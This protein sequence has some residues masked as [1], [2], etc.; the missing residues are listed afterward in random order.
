MSDGRFRSLIVVLWVI[1]AIS[2]AAGLDVRAT[3]GARVS[4][5][6]PQYLL[7]AISLADDGNLNIDDEIDGEAYLPFSEIGLNRQT[8]N[9][10]PDKQV[11]P[12]YP[13]LPL[14]LALP[15]AL[16]GWVGAKLF[17]AAIAGLVAAA[18]FWVAVRRFDIQD[19]HA[20]VVC[21]LF[22]ASAP[23][24]V[25]GTQVYPEIVAAACVIGTVA[26]IT[27]RPSILSGSMALALITALPWLSIKYVPVAAVLGIWAVF[28][29]WRAG[30]RGVAA[31]LIGGFALSGALFVA[32]HLAWY[33]GVTPYA[34]GDHFVGGE[35][36]VVGTSPDLFG[37][38]RRL[39]GLMVDDKFG[40][41][42]WQPAW[43]FLFPAVGA[44]LRRRSALSNWCLAALAVAWLNA[45]F[46]ALTMQG[47][48]WPG[49]QLVVA[50]PLA[51]LLICRWTEGSGRR[52]MMVAIPGAVGIATL[53]ALVTE[54]LQRRV[55]WI[56]DFYEIRWPFYRA[57][58]TVL[59]DYLDVSTATWA[60]H[61]FWVLGALAALV[62]GWTRAGETTEDAAPRPTYSSFARADLR[63]GG[64]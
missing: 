25:Y 18:T 31:W 16:G 27:A 6:E 15:V 54:G 13:L 40:L 1:G 5:D 11:S 55:T 42:A 28:D 36:T 4:A 2:A 39:V 41:A 45:T 63:A 3:Y 22:A 21:S 32:A 52:L 64:G 19:R 58:Q 47:W 9:L 20:A 57:W 62:L 50:L 10:T 30:G 34:V 37:R 53:A 33:G 51:V 24:A 17:L 60:L 35:F 38:S 23:F 12:H 61:G 8:K 43:L 44:A 29:R 7:T 48:W 49:R 56:V 26:A 14:L 46:V 59:P